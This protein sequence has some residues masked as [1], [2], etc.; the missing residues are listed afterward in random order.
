[1]G[2]FVQKLKTDLIVITGM[3]GAGRTEAMHIFE[4]LGYYCIDNL[5]P[6]MIKPLVELM[7]MQAGQARRLA[8]VCDVRSHEFFSQL[9]AELEVLSDLEINYQLLFLDA[10]DEVLRA[11]YSALRRLHP[12]MSS[13]R[14]KNY[15]LSEAIKAERSLL[16]S[17]KQRAHIVVDSSSL[18]PR[19]LR[20]KLCEHFSGV[21]P[22]ETM[23]INVFSFGFKYGNPSEADLIIDVRFLPNPYYIPELKMLTGF[24]K[25]VSD[26]VLDHEETQKFLYAWHQLLDVVIPGYVQEGKQYLS[27]G[28]GCTGGQHRSVA[29]TQE[30]AEYLGKQGYQLSS[31]HRDIHRAKALR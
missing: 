7:D 19:Q 29:I 4:D 18:K 6:S 28:I 31:S 27:I 8:V 17:I 26:Y 14:D 24:D 13:E 20:H 22:Y 25:E 1:M 11:R 23:K 5:P 2:E 12:L 10:K 30:T 16:D 9:S 3:S 15:S 21:S